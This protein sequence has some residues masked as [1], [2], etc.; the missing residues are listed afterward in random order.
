[1][2]DFDEF[3]ARGTHWRALYVNG[4]NII[5]FD[6]FGVGHI[7]KEIKKFIGNMNTSIRFN[8]VW[9]LSCWIY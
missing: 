9:I 2:I 6:R 4:I 3:T 7:P 8:N 5:Y 1:M